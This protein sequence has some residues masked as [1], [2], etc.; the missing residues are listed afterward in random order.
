MAMRTMSM[1]ASTYVGEQLL[2]FMNLNKSRFQ[3]QWTGMQLSSTLKFA[4]TQSLVP[5]IN[6]LVNAKRCQVSSSHSAMNKQ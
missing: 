4:T 1:F 2:S 6:M 3:S 5:D